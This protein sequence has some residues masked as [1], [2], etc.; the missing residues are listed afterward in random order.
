MRSKKIRWLSVS[1]RDLLRLYDFLQE[2]NP[3]AA[4][5]KVQNLIAATEKLIDHPRLGHAC[6]EY[7]GREVRSLI[8]RDYEI[9]YEVTVDSVIILRV[10]HSR[11]GRS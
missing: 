1:E 6:D 8:S 5:R 3:N 2:V 9:R 10:W 7:A 4:A 11:E